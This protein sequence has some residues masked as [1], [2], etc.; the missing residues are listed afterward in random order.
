MD[1]LFADF[2]AETH[3]ELNRVQDALSRLEQGA[4]ASET[5]SDINQGL[6]AVRAA[7]A[8]IG[9]VR[10]AALATGA[11]NFME[12][13][14]ITDAVT[15]SDVRTLRHAV[16][17]I[18]RLVATLASTAAEAPASETEPDLTPANDTIAVAGP[19]TQPVNAPA[20]ET[21]WAIVEAALTST[22][23]QMRKPASII[24]EPS[25]QALPASVVNAASAA[26]QRVVRYLC[27]YSLE[28]ELLRRA[29]GKRG[30]GAVR[31]ASLSMGAEAVIAVS[32]NGAGLDLARLRARAEGLGIEAPAET[33]SQQL[34]DLIFAPR[35]STL[36][37][38]D[39]E[40]GLDRA[41]ASL[42]EIGG[43]IEVTTIAGSGVTFVLRV[44]APALQGAA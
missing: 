14:R 8:G 2:L 9:F 15:P 42:E 34:A 18:G 40:A 24:I 39:N 13:L 37:E 4:A 43:G 10:I 32:D 7:C 27:V 16:D 33:S 6:A 31:I 1:D 35:L 23:A 38:G 22:A 25:A 30:E 26:L 5:F 17:R 12:R 36:G 41:K 44:P 11:L 28:P 3:V 19:R 20:A 29:R 21:P